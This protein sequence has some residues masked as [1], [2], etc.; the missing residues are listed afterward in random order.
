MRRFFKS[1]L[2]A[3]GVW[4]LFLIVGGVFW[5]FFSLDTLKLPFWELQ[6][7]A[8]LPDIAGILYAVLLSLFAVVFRFFYWIVEPK[9]NG[10]R[11]RVKAQEVIM[12]YGIG[13]VLLLLFAVKIALH[14]QPDAIYLRYLMVGA[15][16]ASFI[17][18]SVTLK[19][20]IQTSWQNQAYANR[21][22]YT[23]IALLQTGVDSDAVIAYMKQ[24]HS[25]EALGQVL[26]LIDSLNYTRS[27]VEQL[28][29]ELVATQKSLDGARDSEQKLFASLQGA[30]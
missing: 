12:F 26:N 25:Y 30:L 5:G 3:C 21:R 4:M 23:R 18:A 19:K 14:S 15:P 11:E 1:V 27:R 28:E 22:A 24:K 16:V 6:E 8:Y 9:E 29:E 7:G 2:N 13:G 20:P 10:N 17:F